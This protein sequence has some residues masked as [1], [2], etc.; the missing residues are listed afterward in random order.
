MQRIKFP[1]IRYRFLSRYLQVAECH[2][3]HRLFD[4]K[5]S[6]FKVLPTEAGNFLHPASLDTVF[7]TENYGILG[8]SHLKI[9]QEAET[10]KLLPSCRTPFI[11]DPYGTSIYVLTDDE[12]FDHL[13][14]LQTNASI[15]QYK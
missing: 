6:S 15:M 8:L 14:E 1:L 2:F 11:F 12:H 5:K 10:H 7:V 4:W 3:D 13:A 9:L